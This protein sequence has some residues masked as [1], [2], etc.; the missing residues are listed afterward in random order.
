[1]CCVLR[2]CALLIPAAKNLSPFDRGLPPVSATNGSSSCGDS[3]AVSFS[4]CGLPFYGASA[5]FRRAWLS[6]RKTLNVCVFVLTDSKNGTAN[7]GRSIQNAAPSREFLVAATN[8]YLVAPCDCPTGG[9]PLFNISIT[10]LARSA[11]GELG[12]VVITSCNH[13]R[14]LSRSRLLM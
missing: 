11:C 7:I 3:C 8:C 13:N 12:A 1:V 9:C 10:C 6:L 5:F 14:V 2:F 4:V